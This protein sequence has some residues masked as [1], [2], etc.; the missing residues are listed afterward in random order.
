MKK[1]EFD[2]QQPKC[3]SS[4]I[5]SVEVRYGFTYPMGLKELLLQH[6]GGTPINYNVFHTDSN[7]Y[8]L[9]YVLPIKYGDDL[10][11]EAT[12]ND[13]KDLVPQNKIP[14]AMDPFGNFFLFDK[15][16][17]VIDFI[18]MEELHLTFLA[19]DIN[20]FIDKLKQD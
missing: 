12:M 3:T 18:D 19:S 4:D 20:K 1:L 9:D 6:N 13:I 14:F 10:S 16:N 2:N 15:T 11:F 5:Q 7:D 17:Y 8:Y